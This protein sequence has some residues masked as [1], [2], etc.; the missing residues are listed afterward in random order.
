[1]RTIPSSP[2][3][4]VSLLVLVAAP[5][6]IPIGHGTAMETVQE[7][8]PVTF[9]VL[10]HLRGDSGGELHYNLP[11]LLDEVRRLDPDFAVL[12]GDMIWGDPQSTPAD[13]SWVVSQWVVFDSVMATLHIP[14]YRVPGNHDIS[15]GVTADIYA[16]RYGTLPQAVDIGNQRL[17][18]LSSMRLPDG[19][20][21][22]ERSQR[23]DLDERQLS[24][25][26]DQLG[27]PGA[28]EHAFV[29]MHH[30]L[31]WEAEDAHWW[32]AVHP[33]LAAGGVK[34]V[35]S[36]DYGPQQKFSHARVGGVDYFQ[37]GIA[38]DP[39]ID[40]LQAHEW[41]RILAQQFDNFLHV[42]VRGSNVEVDVET[43]GEV[44]SGHFSPD[45]W[46]A[47]FGRTTRPGRPG[48]R[49]LLAAAIAHPRV[50]LLFA[51]GALALLRLGA[52][53]GYGLG[54]LRR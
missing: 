48:G 10:G 41:N 47:V 29:F 11:E 32:T 39:T 5:A 24:F 21:P 38:P 26:R 4:I 33:I 25:L 52:G 45:H 22:Q 44:T 54:R 51:V 42:T 49:D 6:V 19:S 35:F 50:R 12:T 20:D 46:R 7:P 18:F 36:G 15:D 31:W 17:L 2:Q 23:S 28:Y 9:V 3:R 53:L 8:D 13:S 27:D 1:M 43:V 30:L 14:V 37:S 34:A 40:I 16:R